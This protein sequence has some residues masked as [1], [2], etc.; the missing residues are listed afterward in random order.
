MKYG[1]HYICKRLRMLSYLRDLG[2]EPSGT[3]P[4]VRDPAY[5]VWV[6]DNSP[7]LEQAIDGYFRALRAKNKQTSE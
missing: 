7:E 6:F 3:L 5:N 2:F 1:Q 4:D